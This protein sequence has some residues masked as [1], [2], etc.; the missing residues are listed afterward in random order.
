MDK[1]CLEQ[2]ILGMKCK[3]ADLAGKW[4]DFMKLGKPCPELE[5]NLLLADWG[6]SV[7][8]NICSSYEISNVVSPSNSYLEG[9]FG[10]ADIPWFYPIDQDLAPGTYHLIDTNGV[11]VTFTAAN[12]IDCNFLIANLMLLYQIQTGYY[13][14]SWE[15]NPSSPYYSLLPNF[16]E[17]A[18]DIPTYWRLTFPCNAPQLQLEIWAGTPVI[19]DL[20]VYMEPNAWIQGDCGS[21]EYELPQGCFTEKDVEVIAGKINKLLDKNCNCC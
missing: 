1:C 4:L 12:L 2:H 11:Q 9:S 13:I 21:V 8:E 5:C 3:Y 18:Q 19:G 16:P 6:I 17:W 14:E 7:L 10:N 20:I 15:G